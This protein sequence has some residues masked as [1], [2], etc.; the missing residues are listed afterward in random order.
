MYYRITPDLSVK[1]GLFK[2]P[3]SYEFL[4]GAA[5]IDFVNR[6]TV[7]NQLAPN[8]QIGMQ[9]GGNVSDGKLRYRL[10]V[11]NGN[12][13]GINKN[14]DDYYL[15]V[16]RMETHIALGRK[17]SN[18]IIF[19]INASYEQKDQP[20]SSGNLRAIFEGEQ[21][22]M[23]S[24][25][26]FMY[27]GL[28]VSGE[29]IYSRMVTDSGIQ[30]NPFGYHTTAGYY[31]TSKTQILLRWDRFEGDNLAGDNESFLAG[32]NYF[33]TSYSEIQLNYI[34]PSD[35][36]LEFSQLLLNLQINF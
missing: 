8:R 6:S 28:M 19:G 3:F 36:E 20:S 2:S 33:P 26:R 15:Y 27:N 24:D 4:T 17:E 18:K 31:V 11:F 23:G 14:S 29:F 32:L 5:A 12:G 9:L 25:L 10:G 35:R 34:L 1:A 21:T 16:G 13:L 22:L 7:V 30:S